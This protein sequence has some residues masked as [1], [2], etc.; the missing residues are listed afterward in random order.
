MS[1]TFLHLNI[2][3]TLFLLRIINHCYPV[4]KTTSLII[5]KSLRIEFKDNNNKVKYKASINGM[6]LT[7]KIGTTHS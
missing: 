4:F 5:E 6:N 3:K 7:I 1:F 2:L